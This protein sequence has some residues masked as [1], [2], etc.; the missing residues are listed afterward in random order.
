[1]SHYVPLCRLTLSKAD[2]LICKDMMK[3]GY[4]PEQINKVL[5]EVSP[6]LPMRKA[7]HEQGYCE[8]IVRSAFNSSEVQKCLQEK[9]H[10]QSRGIGF[11]R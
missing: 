10:E 4:K 1:M 5:E 6:E 9:Q 11:S 2:Y 8:N 3:Q 7:E